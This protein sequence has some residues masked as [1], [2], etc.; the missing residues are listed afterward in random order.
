MLHIS[1]RNSTN[2]YL[3]LILVDVC[4][5]KIVCAE[6]VQSVQQSTSFFDVVTILQKIDSM[7]KLVV[8][9]SRIFIAAI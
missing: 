5:E 7:N 6:G 3:L 8:F 2:N 9:I 1:T 4:N